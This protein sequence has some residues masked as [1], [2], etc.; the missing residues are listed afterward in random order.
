VAVRNG[1]RHVVKKPF[2]E[3][4][5]SLLVTRRAEVPALAGKG[6]QMLEPAPAAADTGEAVVKVPAVEITVDHIAYAGTQKAVAGLVALL[7]HPL[8]FLETL[9]DAAVVIGLPG[10]TG[11]VRGRLR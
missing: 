5:H 3:L 4:N 10:V 1:E 2:A 7:I 6:H 8:K 11:M 9:L